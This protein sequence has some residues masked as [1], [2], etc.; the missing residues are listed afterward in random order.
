MSSC[1]GLYIENNIIKYAKVSKD[2]DSFK[3]EAYGLK[4]FDNITET[5]KQIVNET[6]SYRTPISVN[7]SSDK[8]NTVSLFSLLN[9]KDLNKAVKTE[10]EYFC[11]ENKKNFN[12]LEYRNLLTPNLDDK[13]R[14]NNL[15]SYAEKSDIEEKLQILSGYKVNYILP[16]PIVIANLLGNQNKKNK[17]IV[18]IES[19]TSLTFIVDGKVHNVETIDVGMKQVL[20]NI[21]AKENSYAK[22]Y[23]ICKNTTIY[24]MQGRNLQIEENEYME[25]IMPV[26]YNVVEE[27]KKV[28]SNSGILVDEIYITGLASAINNIDLYFQENFLDKKCEILAPFFIEKANIKLNIRDYIEVN[29]AI[30][31]A[32]QGL[33]VGHKEINFKS[34][35]TFD[36]ISEFFN[37]EGNTPSEKQKKN[38]ESKSKLVFK[39]K[40][41]L[42]NEFK[43]SLDRIETGMTRF[44]AGVLIL[45]IVYIIFSSIIISQI[46][47]KETEVQ[48]FITDSKEQISQVT[49]NTILVQKRTEQYNTMIEKIVEANNKLT[50]SYAKKNTLPN[51]LTEIMFNI[52][53]E[54]QLLSIQNTSGK[55]INIEARS[56]EYEQLGYFIAKLKNEGILTDVTST[57]GKKQNGY[58]VVTIQ[59]N[60]PY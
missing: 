6:Y 42:K 55:A 3:V 48:D 15:Y 2:H 26:L 10:F 59:G 40:E 36:Q 7:L 43:T 12:A 11:N 16:L 31:L 5:V 28:I 4:F 53:K 33:G 25:D 51:F 9:P 8:Y 45:L 24:T 38:K 50:E 21:I 34:R 1:L 60:L 30:A 17:V 58:V 39:S 18:N 37:K 13:D 35:G 46:N 27:V 20:D 44:A 57:S 14:V 41:K 22:T 52:P 29:S 54:V 23:E 56:K 19:K 47:K 49:G 32:L